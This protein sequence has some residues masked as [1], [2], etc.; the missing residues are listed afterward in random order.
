MLATAL[1]L[2]LA[3][4]PLPSATAVASPDRAGAH[5]ALILRLHYEMI[6][7]QPGRGPATVAL[8]AAYGVPGS[9]AAAAVRVQGKPAP[10]VTVA[11][12]VVS[13]GLPKPPEVT[14]M[15][16]APGVLTVAFTPAARLRNPAAAG[17]YTIRARTPK[18]AFAARLAI[19]P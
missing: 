16:I 7:G 5:A 9:I 2:L 1:A 11:G 6:C 18:H 17:T 14:C 12:H 15:S 8:P 3:A 4:V 19:R 10:S 13:V